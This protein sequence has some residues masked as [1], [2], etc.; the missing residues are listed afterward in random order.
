MRHSDII[1]FLRR[2]LFKE[3]KDILMR[4]FRGS[5]DDLQDIMTRCAISG[6]WSF[7]KKSRFYRFRAETGA[8]LNWWPSTGTINFQGHDAEHFEA[9]FLEHALAEMGQSEPALVREE[10]AWALLPGPTP[11]LDG[12]R[13]AP[14]SAGTENNRRLASQPLPR[15]APRPVKLLAAP[16]RD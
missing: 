11:P 10:A 8:I 3:T 6:E 15:L 13:E 4:K 16:D 1:Q 2:R 14:S 9:L 7:H 12:S 5:L